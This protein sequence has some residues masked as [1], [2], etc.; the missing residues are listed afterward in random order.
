VEKKEMIKHNGGVR[1]MAAPNFSEDIALR[2][3][4]TGRSI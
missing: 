2:I 1:Q 4:A 3:K